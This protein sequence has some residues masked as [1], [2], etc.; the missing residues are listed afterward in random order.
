[1]GPAL[2]ASE[3]SQFWIYVLG[4]VVGAI[5]G[6]LLYQLVRHEPTPVSA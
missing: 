4:P 2:V 1:L 3:W 5:I 6:A